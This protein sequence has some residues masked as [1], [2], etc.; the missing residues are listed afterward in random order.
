MDRIRRSSRG[1]ARWNWLSPRKRDTSSRV[2]NSS[3]RQ[4]MTD[5]PRSSSRSASSSRT[6]SAS[7]GRRA[8]PPDA[9]FVSTAVMKPEGNALEAERERDFLPGRRGAREPDALHDAAEA[10]GEL[11]L[12]ELGRDALH[13]ADAAVAHDH[14]AHLERS[15]EVGLARLLVRDALAERVHA[16]RDGPVDVAG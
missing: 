5:P 10:R 3:R 9:R 7:S 6:P 11:A 8:T 16:L 12:G 2:S 1:S 4:S 15:G 14:P 13:V